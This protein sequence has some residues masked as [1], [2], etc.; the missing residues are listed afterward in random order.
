ML[1]ST[2]VT[3]GTTPPRFP[4]ALLDRVRAH[5]ADL[6]L[7]G[8]ALAHVTASLLLAPDGLFAKYPRL[9]E[10][11]ASGRL[12]PAEASDASPGYLLLTLLTGPTALRWLQALAGGAAIVLV[13]R[14]GYRL[15]GRVAAWV[16]ALCLAAA[17]PW[18]VHGAVLEPDLL[19]GTLLTGAV[20]A[21]VLGRPERLTGALSAGGALGLA[22]TLRPTALLFALLALA[23]LVQARW[24]AGGRKAGLRHGLAFTAA[25]AA[26]A[27]LP[28]GL[29][30]LRAGQP[31]AATMSA[32]QV[33]HQ[34]HRPEGTGHGPTFPVLLKMVELLDQEGPDRRPDRA[35]Q[36]YRDLAEVAAGSPLPPTEAERYWVDRTL[37]FAR[38]EPGAFA[39]QLGRK[40]VFLVAAPGND[41]DVPDAA[42]PLA[43]SQG[44]SLP[45]GWL[46]LA[47]A[48]GLLLGLRR[49]GPSRLLVAWVLSGA[50]TGLVFYV[51]ARY[52]LAILPAWCL[53]AGSGVAALVEA[54]GEVRR[55][56]PLAIVVALPF[57]LL[58]PG[59]VRDERRLEA[60]QRAVPS[61]SPVDALRRAGKWDEA[62]ALYR[63]EQAA[64]PDQVLPFSR[65]GYGLDADEPALALQ[66][67]ERARTS[68]GETG[69]V[70]AYLLAVLYAASG[71]CDLA[72]PLAERAAE[73]GFRTAV[74][75][76]SLDPDLLIADCLLASGQRG[77]A[78]GRVRR[79]L[80]RSPGTLDGL[81][82]AVAG[83]TDQR[84]PELPR[85]EAALEA[86]HDPASARYALTRQRRRWGDPAG[87]LVDATWLVARFPAAAPY[88]EFERAQALLD[89]GRTQEA[90]QAYARSLVVR[91]AL[92]GTRRFDQPVRALVA[93]RPESLPV[94]QVALSHWSRRGVLGEV[95]ALLARHPELAGG[96][97][98]ARAASPEN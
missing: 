95:R 81:A 30:H 69:A 27:L 43:A 14:I 86:L 70:D 28:V 84:A 94:L 29:L 88:G 63:V 45:L 65:R 83:G 53:L 92:P 13:H 96:P 80:E 24:V 38:T 87:A 33:L 17:Q 15:A 41:T 74:A 71:R 68:Y 58:T 85:W 51:Q 18:M 32:G 7:F 75:D 42:A 2:R 23:W 77:E 19:I 91:V 61:R 40:L 11:L 57:L 54:R 25:L 46:T 12:T 50:L 66:V 93:E 22:A 90:L 5:A 79:S 37:A 1:P 76:A 21:L 97:Q 62:R 26:A 89:L 20:A 16:A 9:A 49:P 48:A 44:C 6:A 34:G 82:R 60:R 78:L 67:A 35:H 73:A 52:S 72:V 31:W 10:A 56:L 8:V 55:W 98:G 59:F 36:L 3:P 64:L 4:R 47:G 39:R